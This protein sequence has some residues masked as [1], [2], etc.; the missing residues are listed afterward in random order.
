MEPVA[1]H[2]RAQLRDDLGE[3]RCVVKVVQGDAGSVAQV[4]REAASGA[5][6]AVESSGDL[7]V[8]VAH[9]G[10]PG[11]SVAARVG[12]CGGERKRHDR[13]VRRRRALVARRLC[14]TRRHGAAPGASGRRRMPAV[15]PRRARP[16]AGQ[17]SAHP[18][19]RRTAA[20]RAQARRGHPGIPP[21]SRRR[22]RGGRGSQTAPLHESRMGRAAL[23]GRTIPRRGTLLQPELWIHQCHIFR[24]HEAIFRIRAGYTPRRPSLC[25]GGDVVGARR[26]ELC[27]HR[28]IAAVVVLTLL[29][30][31]APSAHASDALTRPPSPWRRRPPRHPTSDRSPRPTSGWPGRRRW[32][33]SPST[34][35][36]RAT[37][38]RRTSSARRSSSGRSPPKS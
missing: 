4:P 32:T 27:M 6:H 8:L 7:A 35:S 26:K 13:P 36:A 10:D 20:P 37:W 15:R 19:R 9:D 12:A 16:A 34:S 17:P 1:V 18:S 28:L 30:S 31:A 29:F 2:E 24:Q 21:G 38:R 33:A 14:R 11:D 3:C 22:A 23:T 5:H 25:I